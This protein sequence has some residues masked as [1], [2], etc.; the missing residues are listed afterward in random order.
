LSQSVMANSNATLSVVASGSPTL[1]YQ[2]YQSQ[3]AIAGATP[4]ITNGFVVGITVTNGGAGYL[5]IPNVQIVGGGGSGAA[6]T[7]VVSNGMVAAIDLVSAGSGYT[8]PPAIVIDPPYA[9][10]NDETNSSLTVA[11]ATTND[12]ANYFVVVTNASGSATSSNATLTLNVPVYITAQPQNQSVAQGDGATFSVSVAGTAPYDFQWYVAPV[13][14]DNA[15][16]TA[17]VFDGFV[18]GADV[19]NGGA[20]YANIPN[21]EITGGGGSGATAAAVISNGMVIAI[22]IISA[23]SGYTGTPEIQI[24]PPLV[25]GLNNQTNAVLSLAS[26]ST[27]DAGNYFVVVSNEFASVTSMPATLLVNGSIPF[28]ISQPN[29]ENVLVGTS[30]ALTVE[31]SG[32]PSLTYQW[33]KNGL[34][35]P[36]ATLPTYSIASTGT[37]DTGCYLVIVTNNYGA[38]TSS[39]VKLVVGLPPRQVTLSNHSGNSVQ[40]QMSGTPNFPYAVQVA[41]NLVPPVQWQSVLTNNADT[42]GFWQYSDTNLNQPQQF[43]RVGAP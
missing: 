15:T 3:P 18:Y 16:A 19:I 39:V 27:N 36:T 20:G 33:Q 26:V 41:T 7:A 29:N 28:I 10:L 43:Y 2:W 23:G 6:A 13:T 32:T 11:G 1:A 21:V 8:A 5:T 40:L 42:N 38:A 34:S 4:T 35:L 9:A 24:D 37:N 17:D 25:V 30:V 22:D 14:N 12:A 31:A